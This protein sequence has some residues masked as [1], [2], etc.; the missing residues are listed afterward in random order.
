M[1]GG[2][3]EHGYT[4]DKTD[5]QIHAWNMYHLA[6]AALIHAALRLHNQTMIF[7]S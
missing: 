6:L 2:I 4:Q 1:K 5:V 3:T 7:G